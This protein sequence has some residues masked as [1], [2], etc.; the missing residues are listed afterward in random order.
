MGRRNNITKNKSIYTINKK[1]MVSTAGTI[2]E[3]DHVTIIRDDGIFDEAPS[4]SDSNFKYRIGTD[5][6]DK[7]KHSRG[8]WV[9]PVEGD[10]GET[11]TLS[12]LSGHVKTEETKIVNKP[13]YSSMK[14]FAYYGSAV[15]LLKATVNDIIIR[16]PGG[17]SYYGNNAPK[18]TIGEDTYYLVS[19]EFDIDF[20]TQGDVFSGDVK[21]PLRVLCASYGEYVD[22]EGN[23]ISQPKVQIFSNCLESIIGTVDIIGEE[24][25][26]YIYLNG[27]GKKILMTKTDSSDFT[28]KEL[29]IIRPNEK[30]INEFWNSLDDF[31]RV[32]LNRD[33]E[34]VYKAVFETPYSNETGFYYTPESYVWPTVGNDGFTPDMTTGIFR[35][36]LERLRA[37]AE[38]HDEYDSDN[39]LRMYTH[40]PI[41]NL[42]WTFLDKNTDEV[43]TGQD[44]NSARMKAMLHVWGRQF[45]DLKLYAENVK[46]TNTITY[47]EKNNVPDYF[48]TDKVEMNGFEAKTIAPVK[49]ESVLSDTISGT[50]EVNSAVTKEWVLEKEKKPSDVNIKFMRRLA[51]CAPFI[52]AM[53]GTRRGLTTILNMFGYTEDKE[54]PS[55]QTEGTFNIREYV[56]VAH[57]FPEYAEI[58]RLRALG[59][60]INA[61]D[62]SNFMEGY[63]VAKVNP[64]S[65][66][67]VPYIIPWF[68]NKTV[69][70]D[71]MYFQQKGGWGRFHK[72]L[73]S[74][75][76]TTVTEI[77]EREDFR[78]YSETE[79]YMKFASDLNDLRNIPNADL[80]E[81]MVCYVSDISGLEE[82]YVES[83]EDAEMW[84]ARVHSHYF[85]LKKKALSQTIGYVHN[86]WYDCYGWRNIYDVEYNGDIEYTDDGLRVL[87]LES[88]TNEQQ[89]NNPHTGKGEYDDGKS[90]LDRYNILF[91]EAL[92]DGIYD[93]LK[94]SQ[95]EGDRNDYAAIATSGFCTSFL[96]DS[97]IDNK[98]SHYFE[99]TEAEEPRLAC[100]QKEGDEWVEVEDENR[101]NW[102]EDFFENLVIPEQET[103]TSKHDEAAANSVV[104]IKN[105]VISFGTG[106]NQ[107][108]RE[109]LEKVV[110][111]YL[112]T[113][114]PSTTI[115]RYQFDTD[116]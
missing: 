106:G 19:N 33:S 99:D 50:I 105:I 109:Y 104:N 55:P 21:N 72:K 12:N 26:F 24:E 70:R 43:A 27:E 102:D 1:H 113:M 45:D 100:L 13:N 6:D 36:Y 80:F 82:M 3:K 51:L 2:Y 93:Y 68:D 17:L 4:F 79:T 96:E 114:I 83:E 67:N 97:D 7:K 18:M 53:K 115:V 38:F 39:I 85:I 49:S 73:I 101:N 29:F 103:V 30:I 37:L 22:R 11:W 74:L 98:K 111:K 94:D 15:E 64:S 34:P 77:E 10:S 25:L 112:E 78:I 92:K 57:Y 31:E 65:E 71:P 76:I 90:Y 110:I 84:E 20:Y 44:F 60:Y 56:S 40:E 75:P 88:L 41:K 59:E 14:D 95:D 61:G 69:Y 9:K 23:V 91:S 108:L 107:Y 35:G 86:D 46:S 47:D 32:L 28:L 116:E 62:V 52:T 42:D 87:Y 81:G 48:L 16:F 58:S 8:V 66:E 54:N 63:P 89:G 5:K